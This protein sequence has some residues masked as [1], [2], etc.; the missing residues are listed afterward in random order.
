MAS[1][2]DKLTPKKQAAVLTLARGCTHEEAVEASGISSRQ[3]CR[4]KNEPEFQEA[5]RE[6][7]REIYGQAIAAIVDAM[8]T[9]T[10]TLV[11]ICKNPES[12]DAARVS[13]ARSLLENGLKA[14]GQQDLTERVEE[15]E[16]YFSESNQ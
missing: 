14:F 16:G 11:D 5:I 13:A 10:T 2:G 6:A 7:Q 3:L 9:A 12:S 15:L 8:R 4:Y 1:S